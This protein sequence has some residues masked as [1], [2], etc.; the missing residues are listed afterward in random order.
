MATIHKTTMNLDSELMAHARNVLGTT[1]ATA[2]VEAA[3][4]DVV[5]RAELRELLA[6][7]FSLLTGELI[8]SLR[9]P[10]SGETRTPA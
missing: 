10:T 6:R 3:L 8:D 4:R 1:S 9:T 5:R 2:T 7:D